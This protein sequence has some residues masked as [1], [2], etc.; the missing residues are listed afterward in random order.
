V[1]PI[2]A[3]PIAVFGFIIHEGV[4]TGPTV[5]RVV[6][7]FESGERLDEEQFAVA[8]LIKLELPWDEGAGFFPA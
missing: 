5:V 6:V 3:A 8:A 4:R 7:D 2:G 1:A